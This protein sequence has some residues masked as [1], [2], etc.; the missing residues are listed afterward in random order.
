MGMALASGDTGDTT[1]LAA[2]LHNIC[3][4]CSGLGRLP[5]RPERV[6]LDRSYSA[7][8][9]RAWSR[10]SGIAATIRER[11]DQISHRRKKPGRPFDPA[12]EKKR[13]DKGRTVDECCVNK[14]NQG[15]G[16][17]MRSDKFARSD[18]ADICLLAT[19]IWRWSASRR[20]PRLVSGSAV[21]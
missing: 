7:K 6:L 1:M 3:V 4:P 18:G 15:R 11:D 5:T 21:L 10:P 20:R 8:A 13:G 12:T 16:I 2:M 14:L 9:N 17:A 19:L